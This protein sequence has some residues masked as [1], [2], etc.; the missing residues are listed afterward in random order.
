MEITKKWFLSQHLMSI[1]W[2]LLTKLT[3]LTVLIS[4]EKHVQHQTLQN[5]IICTLME[6]NLTLIAEL[7]ME[8]SILKNPGMISKNGQIMIQD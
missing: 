6:I 8:I 1:Q 3:V 4:M 2:G 7:T 5:G